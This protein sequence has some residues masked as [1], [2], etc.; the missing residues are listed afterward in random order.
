MAD[1]VRRSSQ[2]PHDGNLSLRSWYEARDS[3]IEI[4]IGRLFFSNNIIK[5]RYHIWRRAIYKLAND[6]G[7]SIPTGD[8]TYQVLR[9]YD[10]YL[11]I[12]MEAGK[13]GRL[14][15]SLVWDQF[16]DD[17]NTIVDCSIQVLGAARGST[18]EPYFQLSMGSIA[19][20]GFV[21]TRCRDPVIRRRAVATLESSYLQDG[22]YNSLYVAAVARRMIELEEKGHQV[23][24]SKDIP[25]EARIVRVSVVSDG[26]ITPT[27]Q[28]HYTHGSQVEA[29]RF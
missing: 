10:A 20:L 27:V 2:W 3:F 13:Q 26:P 28:F 11:A 21:A 16:R 24:S 15:D 9:L 1:A 17:F 6:E 23:I 29:L 4:S 5:E 18:A 14:A 22:L 7:Q 25:V 12:E 19:L 8:A